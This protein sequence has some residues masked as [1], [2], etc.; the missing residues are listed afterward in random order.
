MT[1]VHVNVPYSMLLQRIDFVIERRIHPEIYFSA[2]ALDACQEKDVEQ[3][4]QTLQENQL[5]ATLHGPFMDL[6]PGGV[7]QRIKEVTRDRLS[8]TI[9]VARYL[10]PRMIVFHPGYESWKF[11]GNVKLWLESSLQTWRPLVREAEE[12]GLTLAVENVFEESPDPIK[13]L[14]EEI[15]SPRFRFCFDTGHHHVFAKTPL[16]VWMKALGGFLAEVHLHDNHKETDEH[17]PV[18]EGE[19]DFDQFFALLSQFN[20][21]PLFTI[22]PHDEVHLQRGLLA[23]KK[24]VE[25]RA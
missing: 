18:G 20:L 14:L 23:V 7:D 13:N 5:E 8:K 10:A 11:D 4:S 9:Q 21:N 24:Y 12:T 17:L 16:H 19:F 1:I 3:L 2:E 22:E 15:H 25:G 6:S